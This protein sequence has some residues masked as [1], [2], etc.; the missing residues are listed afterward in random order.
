MGAGSPCLGTLIN[1]L[2]CHVIQQVLGDGCWQPEFGHPDEQ[3][4]VS[5]YTAGTG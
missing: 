1:R 2:E 5:C 4:R 3:V